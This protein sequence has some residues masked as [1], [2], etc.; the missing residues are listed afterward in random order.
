M[1]NAR[2][3]YCSVDKN[4]LFGDF[5]I[6]QRLLLADSASFHDILHVFEQIIFSSS[7]SGNINKDVKGHTGQRYSKGVISIS[8]TQLVHT[9][10]QF[11]CT[12]L[13]N[14]FFQQNNNA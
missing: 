1:H 12:K 9:F 7:N 5:R 13:Y 4:F 8:A 11:T 14:S 10:T 2:T 3:S 6:F